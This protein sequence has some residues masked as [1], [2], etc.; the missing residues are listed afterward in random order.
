MPA[1]VPKQS[2][3]ALRSTSNGN[4]LHIAAPLGEVKLDINKATQGLARASAA[5]SAAGRGGANA[6]RARRV[7]AAA[8]TPTP[9]PAAPAL[10]P[11]IVAATVRVAATR[12]GGGSAAGGGGAAA[13]GGAAVGGSATVGGN[14]AGNNGVGNG[15]GGSNLLGGVLGTVNRTA[16]GLTKKLLSDIRLK[17]DIVPVGRLANGL[18]L[19]RY[20]YLWSDTA[21][22]GVMAQEVELVRPDAVVRGTD[23]YLR[24]DYDALGLTFQTFD[25]WTASSK[26][27]EI[28]ASARP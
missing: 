14:G 7:T 28:T 20:R 27:K 5:D 1:P 9:R 17:R 8:T 19:Y 13:G 2:Q 11:W 4:P 16:N 12:A 10:A 24:V 18:G 23:G 3:P 22:V 26:A 25:E 15:N 21:Y 6:G